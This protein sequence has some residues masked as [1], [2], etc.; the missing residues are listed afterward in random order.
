[1]EINC[2]F[3]APPIVF[4]NERQYLESELQEMQRHRWVTVENTVE[5]I[6]ANG[7]TVEEYAFHLGLSGREL[8][9]IIGKFSAQEWAEKYADEFHRHH[10]Q[11]HSRA[12]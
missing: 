7:M 9:D 11:D 5:K 3:F 2:S 4:R 10:W 1:M 8:I 6:A 12:A